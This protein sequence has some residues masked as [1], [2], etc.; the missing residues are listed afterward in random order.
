MTHKPQSS[1]AFYDTQEGT[2]IQRSVKSELR[3]YF[4]MLDGHAPRD[5]HR[6]VM[7]QAEI[8]LLESVMHECCGNQS[9]AANWLG[10]S[11]GTLRCKLAESSD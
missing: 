8:A 10:I 9:K 2:A 3:R 1:P 6:M 4:D 7:R 5:L 11:R